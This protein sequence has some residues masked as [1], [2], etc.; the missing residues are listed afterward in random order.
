MHCAAIQALSHRKLC[1][2]AGA[3]GPSLKSV[4]RLPTSSALPKLADRRRGF[5]FRAGHSGATRQLCETQQRPRVLQSSPAIQ[6][7][8]DG[9]RPEPKI[10]HPEGK[11]DESSHSQKSKDCGYHQAAS[12]SE[13]KPEQRPEDLAAIPGIDW[14]TVENQHA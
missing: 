1:G 13:H 9:D 8:E 5:T 10:V 3:D 14:Q 7:H 4:E 6:Q 11:T 2:A 12:A